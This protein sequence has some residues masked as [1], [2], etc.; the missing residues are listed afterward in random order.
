MYLKNKNIFKK[1]HNLAE[2]Q[3][4]R[5]FKKSDPFET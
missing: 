2:K 4:P 5:N 1:E 3:G